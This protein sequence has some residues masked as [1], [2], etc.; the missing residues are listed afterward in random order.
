MDI[1][2]LK[3]RYR[4]V[5]SGCFLFKGIGNIN[6]YLENGGCTLETFE[7][8]DVIFTPD[9]FFRSVGIIL[10][11][12]IRI[13]NE[14]GKKLIVNTLSKGAP[15]GVASVFSDNSEYE[16]TL[17]ATKN[18][19]VLFFSQELLSVMIKDPVIAENYI[20]FLTG[21]IHFLNEKIRSLSCTDAEQSLAKYVLANEENGICFTGNLS[22]LAEKLGMGR[23]SLYRAFDLLT[24]NELIYRDGKKITVINRQKLKEISQ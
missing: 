8:G 18:C 11:G 21:R 17:T 6:S 20:R 13:T 22:T 14:T 19:T 10:S 15:F 7:K 24:K 12:E 2:L 1:K 23:A 16:T 9:K 5:I 3:P 4:D